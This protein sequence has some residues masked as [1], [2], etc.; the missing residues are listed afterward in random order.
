MLKASPISLSQRINRRL[1]E[2]IIASVNITY[3]INVNQSEL[4]GSNFSQSSKITS[5]QRKLTN[6][7]LSG[8]LTTFL[9]LNAKLSNSTS[10]RMSSASKS[11]YHVASSYSVGNYKAPPTIAP[12]FSPAFIH[13]RNKS[14]STKQSID[15][16]NKKN[17]AIL[18]SE[19]LSKNRNNQIIYDTVTVNSKTI[20]GGCS[21]WLSFCASTTNLISSSLSSQ[22]QVGY[23]N[24]VSVLNV[25]S[26][27]EVFSCNS[28]GK[29]KQ[30]ATSLC[31]SNSQPTLVNV[32][33]VNHRW[34][35]ADCFVY[36]SYQKV[37]CVDCS[38]P[39]AEVIGSV[40]LNP[41]VVTNST[42][43]D[44]NSI[45]I[46]E[47]GFS[48]NIATGNQY[49]V[50]S[51]SAATAAI[52]FMSFIFGNKIMKKSRRVAAVQ[53]SQQ[54]SH[55]RSSLPFTS[56]HLLLLKPTLGDD[57]RNE[58]Y[59]SRAI[60]DEDSSQLF[61]DFGNEMSFV[62][63]FSN[64]L[65]NVILEM[66][67]STLSSF[68][69]HVKMIGKYVL[70]KHSY[71]NWGRSTV[72][73]V[74]LT[75]G[76]Y[77][78]ARVTSI[79]L[80]STLIILLDMPSEESSICN[81]SHSL[82]PCMEHVT[83]LSRRS[84]CAWLPGD[85]YVS[86]VS[87]QT[88]CIWTNPGLSYDVVALG[89]ASSV[90]LLRIIRCM[91]KFLL[92]PL[93][94][95]Q[96]SFCQPT[97][98]SHEEFIHSIQAAEVDK[99]QL[100]DE[101]SDRFTRHIYMLRENG[102]KEEFTTLTNKWEAYNSAFLQ[103]IL[104][105][106]ILEMDAA[107]ND[108]EKLSDTNAPYVSF[109]GRHRRTVE[110]IANELLR[111]QKHVQYMAPILSSVSSNSN[112]FNA[113]LLYQFV[114]DTI[115][116]DSAV[117][118]VF[119]MLLSN[120]YLAE[121]SRLLWNTSFKFA[122]LVI[123]ILTYECGV[124]LVTASSAVAQSQQMQLSFIGIAAVLLFV[125]VCVSEVIEI[126]YYWYLL[127]MCIST[128]VSIVKRKFSELI[129]T[130]KHSHSMDTMERDSRDVQ[131]SNYSTR[132]PPFTFNLNGADA[133]TEFSAQ[134]FQN[135]SLIIAEMFPGFAV[136]KIISSYQ[137]AFPVTVG[138]PHWPSS[139]H[140]VRR[141]RDGDGDA[142]TGMLHQSTATLLALFIVSKLPT[143]V[144]AVVVSLLPAGL[145]LCVALLGK[146]IS[147]QPIV[148]AVCA[149]VATLIVLFIVGAAVAIALRRRSRIRNA[150]VSVEPWREVP[151]QS[152]GADKDVSTS[153]NGDPDQDI[154]EHD[155]EKALSRNS[156]S[157]VSETKTQ[158]SLE[159]YIIAPLN[160][161]FDDFEFDYSM[162]DSSA[163]PVEGSFP[164]AV[165]IEGQL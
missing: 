14:S 144:Q 67:F 58:C 23:M 97:K 45:V 54:A 38:D 139:A 46:I 110:V 40:N 83:T 39:C 88:S 56:S 53:E 132:C 92:F 60:A 28:A 24:F 13:F 112:M 107:T 84:F 5:L 72:I 123:A 78:V 150:S 153:I 162:V 109:H 47:V 26:P 90:V 16:W 155:G 105:K 100:F 37:V 143:D 124:G 148:G 93:K 158:D 17:V 82:S 161:D 19:I 128:P 151:T 165:V 111:V 133:T 164:A 157:V 8:N 29:V 142:G 118:N 145:C 30:I 68:G 48:S 154:E 74:R 152:V 81:A 79:F 31:S 114:L 52:L 57:G 34:I 95:S 130:F 121:E 147:S 149:T 85:S 43:K 117:A 1:L 41:C 96:K 22:Y 69:I 75:D 76:L 80:L 64:N 3:S 131:D 87:N 156:S 61:P 51:Y 99:F 6:G 146:A 136:S 50:L 44:Q 42:V 141:D 102:F 116:K 119:V 71:F 104:D 126:L 10:L 55:S 62:E 103:Y 12:T 7:I 77:V 106:D 138:T 36:N 115:G 98:I 94:P 33:C 70:S 127:P 59:R 4:G 125:D 66:E 101:F 108:W 25:S 159:N 113:N 21:S 63:S 134:K 65:F 20:L 35:I 15:L 129:D 122:C 120:Q 18:Q 137:E 2:S 73:M 49:W 163:V 27:T 91:G 140:Y 135:P 86:S 32:S 89:I 9:L 11:Q 160:I